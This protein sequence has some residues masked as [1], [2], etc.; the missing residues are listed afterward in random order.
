MSVAKKV[1][2]IILDMFTILIFILFAFAIYSFVQIK[3][4][5]KTHVNMF[6]YTFLQVVSGSMEDEIKIN[7]IIIDKVLKPGDELKV[8]DIIS[9]EEN[10]SII[11]HRI[12]DISDDTITTKGDANN[13]KDD[14]INREQVIGK[15]IKIIPNISI[16][17]SVFK[18]RSV[19][20]LMTTTF[21]L[22]VT[23]LWID[24]TDEDDNKNEADKKDNVEETSEKEEK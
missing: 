16:W 13:S 24:T 17:I 11:T 23:T 12:I 14:P 9:F 18:T 7:D 21:V 3:V 19:Y 22:F 10:N 20:I 6:G 8:G 15:V 4:L 5:N 2:S 1:F